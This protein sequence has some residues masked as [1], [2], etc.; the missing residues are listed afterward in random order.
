MN[1]KLNTVI[2]V[3]SLALAIASLIYTYIINK[4]NN[5][6]V[7]RLIYK[8][9]ID[10]IIKTVE[11]IKCEFE[12]MRYFVAEE[13]FNGDCN[14]SLIIGG[15][16]RINIVKLRKNL[17]KFMCLELEL[18][19]LDNIESTL[20]TIEYILGKNESGYFGGNEVNKAISEFKHINIE[21]Y[22]NTIEKYIRVYPREFNANND[23]NTIQ[24]EIKHY[25]DVMNNISTHDVDNIYSDLDKEYNNLMNT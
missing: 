7:A 14:I 8:E 4:N 16:I 19:E 12:V 3:I 21:K 5:I 10:N 2:S 25:I 17:H 23:S 15:R 13:H 6:K 24:I 11:D 9:N 20:Y 22:I 18:N 1:D